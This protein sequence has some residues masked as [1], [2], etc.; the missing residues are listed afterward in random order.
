M[1]RLFA[2]SYKMLQLR[3]GVSLH[4]IDLSNEVQRTYFMK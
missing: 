3:N 2:E 1:T 4:I